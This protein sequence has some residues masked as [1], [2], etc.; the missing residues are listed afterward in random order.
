MNALLSAL[1]ERSPIAVQNAMISVYGRRLLRERMDPDFEATLAWLDETDRWPAERHAAYQRERL[2]HVV[3][4]A[5][6]N[7]PFWR[8]TMEA[9]G[10]RPADIAT[11]DGLRKLPVLRREEVHRHFEEMRSRAARRRDLVLGHTSGTTG[12]PLEFWW[13]HRVCVW[14][15]ALEY[16]Y[17]SWAGAR[18]GDLTATL[19]GNV[20]VPLRQRRPPFWRFCEPWK[21]VFFSSFHLEPGHLPSYVA[22]LRALGRV[23]LEAY[24]STAYVLA[25]FLE[26]TD[27]E[28]ELAGVL[29]S[30]ETLTPAVREVIERRFRARAWDSYSMSERVIFAGE[31]ELHSGQHLFP[32][33]GIVEV[34]DEN[35]EP[36]P[37]GRVGRLVATGLQNLAMPLLRYDTGDVGGFDIEPCACGRTYP[38][39]LPIMTKAEDIVVTPEGRYVSSS[40]L[41]HPFKPM[42]NIVKSQLVQPEVGRLTVRIVRRPSYTERDSRV[43]VE[44]LRQRLGPRIRIDLEFVDDIARSARGKYRWVVSRVPLR[45]GSA[46]DSNLFWS[47]DAPG[48]REPHAS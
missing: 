13:D 18:F 21:R 2:R 20:I 28:L 4:H 30:S 40:V 16:H 17:R 26:E 43:L 41:T 39:L 34:L 19:L 47:E 31:C 25:Q 15:N 38:K 1:Y 6:A 29:L 32:A 14:N 24:P 35:D 7:V 12:S 8:R 46:A 5:W 27:D 33:F 22:E 36:V 9:R 3:E 42:V 37:P 10:L 48:E 23:W 44:G 11:I 45:L